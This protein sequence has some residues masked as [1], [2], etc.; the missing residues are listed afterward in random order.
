MPNF[1]LAFSIACV[2]SVIATALVRIFAL[3]KG[4]VDAPTQS[5]KIH[6]KPI[7]LL[8][9]VGVYVSVVVVML[10]YAFFTDHLV[11]GYLLFKHVIGVIV[12]GGVLMLGGYFD[13]RYNLPPKTQIL[14][15]LMAV[16]V[17][18]VSGIGITAL[19]NPFFGGTIYFDQLK[20]EVVRFGGMPYFISIFSDLL[21]F[22]WLMGMM[23]TTKYLDGLDGLVGGVS[24]IAASVIFFVS[25]DLTLQQDYMALMAIIFAGALVGFLFF[26][27][28]PASIFL[29]EGGSLFAGF[30]IG[31]MAIMSGSKIA[32]ALLVFGIP[33]F[34]TAWVIARRLFTGKKITQGDKQH[35]HHRLLDL[36]LRQRTVALLL[37]ALTAVFG[38]TALF[39]Q[40]QYK[41]YVLGLLIVCMILF[42]FVLVGVYNKKKYGYVSKK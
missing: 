35:L 15:P 29:G 12:G 34:D 22:A 38:A 32:T 21:T 24:L 20:F 4:I 30:M 42:A 6:K 14:F 31:V 18:L 19:S 41:L 9:G 17:V 1:I 27:F 25:Q 13:D 40:T 2:V 37:Y 10:G 5:R 26:N 11:T 7:P 36:G 33:I 16:L 23:Y 39:L 3:K 8:G 28:N